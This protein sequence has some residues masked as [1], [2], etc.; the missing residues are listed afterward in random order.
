MTNRKIGKSGKNSISAKRILPVAGNEPGAADKRQEALRAPLTHAEHGFWFW[1]FVGLAAVLFFALPLLSLDAGNSGDED[2][3]RIPQ[4]NHVLDF[5]QSGGR[6]STG[7][8]LGSRYYGASFDVATA[9]VNRTLGIEEIHV[10]RHLF[11]AFFGWTAILFAGLI[12]CRVGGWRAGVMTMA[13]LF[14]SPRFLGHAY[15]NPKDI[16][17]AAA[18][19]AGCYFMMRFFG[20]FPDVKIKTAVCLALSIALAVSIRI[21]GLILFG[22]FGV[23]GLI[24]LADIYFAG[25]KQDPK[26]AVRLLG[27][28]V[29]RL[30]LYG[31]AICVTGY[32]AGLI[33]WPYALMSPVAHPLEAFKAMSFYSTS[34]G[35]LFEGYYTMSADL[36]RYYT[37]K[38]ILI[39]TPLAVTLGAMVYLFAGGLK[40]AVRPATFMIYFAFAF[41]V[42]WI[43]YTGANVYGGWRHALFVCPPMAVAAGLGFNALAE[44][45][46]RRYLKTALI[47]LPFALLAMPAAHIVRNHPHEY[48]YFNALAGGIDGAYGNYETDYYFHS[49]RAAAEWVK[50][51]ARK[52]GLETGD[53]IVVGSWHSASVEYFLRKDTAR[54]RT[55]F[56]RWRERSTTDWDYAIFPLVGMTPQIIKSA[57]FPPSNTVHTIKVDDKPICLI[58]KR[59][60]KSA[61]RAALLREKYNDKTLDGEQRRKLFVEAMT[62][63]LRAVEAEPD[64][65]YLLI[66][67]AQE[68]F[69]AGSIDMSAHYLNQVIE[70]CADE[71][72]LNFAAS[73]YEQYAERT[74][75][76]QYAEQ[77]AAFRRRMVSDFPRKPK[78]YYDL[79]MIYAGKG[80]AAAG[81]KLMDDCMKK[82]GY[83]FDS[84]YYMAYYLSHTGNREAALKILD[85]CRAKFPSYAS[86]VQETR[87]RIEQG[88]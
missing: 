64:E 10:T 77:M 28:R 85:K 47:A 36:P 63:Y 9:F 84:Y 31:F 19:T 87:L 20:R 34:L 66:T 75:D 21:G 57:H 78:Y 61:Y 70:Y 49:T 15:N 71:F 76:L 53:K 4:G 37:P 3:Y 32:F 38:Y 14:L 42:F 17:F 88:Q 16:P 51:N 5:Y 58:L 67:L 54:F 24:Y 45:A 46:K 56:V 2:S 73:M 6:D 25:R 44:R 82:N 74:K 79:A 22:Y 81:K 29:P 23:F 65:F 48:V 68:C 59:S 83:L 41:P 50:A 60:D 13:L 30:L 33:L 35:Q 18:I 8:Y 69:N 12:A 86:V 72:N 1:A 43:A 26:E 52:S 11:N 80:N 39:T 27:R 62:G 55:A 40:R 7:L